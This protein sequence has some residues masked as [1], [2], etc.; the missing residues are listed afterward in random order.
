MKNTAL[1]I[2][3]MSVFGLTPL[4]AFA[5]LGSQDVYA[6]I[7]LPG[8]IVGYARPLGERLAVRADFGTTG[9]FTRTEREDAIEYKGKL[10]YGRV[11]IL[12]DYFPLG[13]GFRLTGGLT[14]NDTS[15]TLDAQTQPGSSLTVNGKT[16]VLQ[17]GDRFRA[18]AE[19]P[20]VTPYIGLGWGHQ[21]AE[22]GLGFVAD[23]G[24]SIGRAKVRIDENISSN[25]AYAGAISASDV[26]A[27]KQKLR[28]GVAK[29]NIQPQISIGLRYVF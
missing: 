13:G 3:L 19:F 17:G 23:I 7:G 29:V 10:K 11:A 1:L 5:Q 8:L 12:G 28:D 16:V 6:K 26:E 21:R 20:K 22:K 14:F 24:A 27:E 18:K 4:S 15:L 2:S 25:P 9:S